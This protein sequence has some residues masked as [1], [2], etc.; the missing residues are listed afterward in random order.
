MQKF[1]VSY[2]NSLFIPFWLHNNLIISSRFVTSTFEYVFVMSKET[3]F[4]FLSNGISRSFIRWVVP[5]TLKMCRSGMYISSLLE[6]FVLSLHAR[7][8][9]QLM[10]GLIGESVLCIFFKPLIVVGEGLRY[11][12]FYFSSLYISGCLVSLSSHCESAI[13]ILHH[14]SYYLNLYKR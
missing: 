4:K 14:Q 8:F 6:S 10:I 1:V 7:T 3:D 11:M 5:F 2:C 12:Y 13:V 9:F